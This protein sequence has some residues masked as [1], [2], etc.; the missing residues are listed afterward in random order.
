MRKLHVKL[1][2]PV[3]EIKASAEDSGT[4]S[5]SLIIGFRRLPLKQADKQLDAFVKAS[6]DW[7][8]AV[9]AGVPEEELETLNEL[10]Q[11]IIIDNIL[12]LRSVDL[13]VENTDTGDLQPLKVPDTRKAK[14][15]EDFWETPAECLD[16]LLDMYFQVAPWRSSL[17]TAFQDAMVNMKLPDIAGKVEN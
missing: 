1:Q 4:G 5:D 17:S 16:V 2:T 14:K 15:D 10:M 8:E 7:L 13:R 3:I 9:K 6:G 12:Y 11:K